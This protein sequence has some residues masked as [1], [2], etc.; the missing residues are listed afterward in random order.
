MSISKQQKKALKDLANRIR[1]VR[2]QKGLTQEELA[3]S[4]GKDKQ[5]IQRLERGETSP[6]YLSLLEVC[7]G[8]EISISDLLRGLNE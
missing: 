7:E 3:H 5:A 1:E 4:I 2:L 6:G 8:L